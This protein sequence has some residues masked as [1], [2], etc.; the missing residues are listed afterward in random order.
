MQ[1]IDTLVDC[2]NYELEFYLNDGL[3]TAL[4][5]LIFEDRRIPSVEFARLFRLFVTDYTF[6]GSYEITYRVFLQSYTMTS[7]E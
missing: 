1:L 3:H 4:N 6:I 5:P 7:T 2:G